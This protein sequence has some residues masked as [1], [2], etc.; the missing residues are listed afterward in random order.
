MVTQTTAGM[1][2]LGVPANVTSFTFVMDAAGGGGGVL[3]ASG[4]AGGTVSGT[5]TI[6][7][8][9]IPTTI[10]AIVRDTGGS[11]NAGTE[12]AGGAGGGGSA[13][14]GGTATISVSVSSASNGGGSAGGA[15]STAGTPGSVSFIGSGLPR[16]NEPRGFNES[17]EDRSAHH[18]RSGRLAC[19]KER[20]PSM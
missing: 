19:A 16:R 11:G 9:S 12:G 1:Y 2:T 17:I 20:V 15:A 3:V 4:G 7:S 18:Q 14:T 13:Y 8:S 6:P 10:I 5:S